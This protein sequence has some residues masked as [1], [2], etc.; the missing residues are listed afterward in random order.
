MF[1]TVK[2]TDAV[3]P[4]TMLWASGFGV[5]LMTGAVVMVKTAVVTL[6]F[7]MPDL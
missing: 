4:G 6:L 3:V 1:E 2:G 5:M 7:V